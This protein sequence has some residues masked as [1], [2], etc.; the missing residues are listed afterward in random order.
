M[1]DSSENTGPKQ[2]TRFQPGQSGN[3]RGRPRGS[4]NQTTLAV[5]ALL[6]GE[7]ETLTRKAIELATGGDIQ[8]LR[9]CL[10]RLCPPRREATVPFELPKIE[11]AADA[12]K[13]MAAIVTAV[14][15]G[16]LTPGEA[17]AI[18]ALVQSFS[19]TI[20]T[21]DLEARIAKLERATCPV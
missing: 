12:V 18:S 14:A 3:P 16:D 5:E 21:A 19:K 7:A 13:A 2:D 8:A 1:T 15:D 20:E 10:D 9:I 17:Q 6:D 4:R 11:T